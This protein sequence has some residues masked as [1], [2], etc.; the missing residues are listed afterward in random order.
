MQRGDRPVD[1]VSNQRVVQYVDMEMEDVE[2]V[3]GRAHLLE[4]G[5]MKWNRILDARVEA[6]RRLATRLQPRRRPQITA[7][8]QR[9]VVTTPDQFLRKVRYD[10]LGAAV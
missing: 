2:L 7:G 6:K 9:N 10:P 4:H 3:G 5:D 1:E 8:E